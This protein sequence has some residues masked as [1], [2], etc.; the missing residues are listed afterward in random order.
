MHFRGGGSRPR[1]RDNSHSRAFSSSRGINQNLVY[2]P[3]LSSGR[4]AP[5][6][7]Y[8]CCKILRKTER[9]KKAQSG[10]S[11]SNSTYRKQ[12][13]ARGQRSFSPWLSNKRRQACVGGPPMYLCVIQTDSSKQA[14]PVDL[15]QEAWRQVD[16]SGLEIDRRGTVRGRRARIDLTT[17]FSLS[18]FSLFVC[19]RGKKRRV[20]MIIIACSINIVSCASG[21]SGARVLTKAD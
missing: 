11:S 3:S 15:L 13:A 10:A 14:S 12:L 7:P 21:T 2:T 19:K 1:T 4:V 20:A 9:E 5:S 16:R 8:V 18:F 17:F 6:L